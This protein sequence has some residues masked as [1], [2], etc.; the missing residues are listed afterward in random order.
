MSFRST[1][2]Q[3]E[4]CA[5]LTARLRGGPYWAHEGDEVLRPTKAAC[6][7]RLSLS[8]GELI[9]LRVAWAVWNGDLRV[10]LGEMLNTLD[11]RNLRMVGSLLVALGSE[12]GG[13]TIDVWLREWTDPVKLVGVHTGRWTS[14]PNIRKNCER[15]ECGGSC[16]SCVE[17]EA[18]M[19]AARDAD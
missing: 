11:G 18:A 5:V 19:R 4:V 9:M 7:K 8:H 2:Q 3:G 15:G 10:K 12:Q 13:R 6:S 17:H 1:K 14:K 16:P